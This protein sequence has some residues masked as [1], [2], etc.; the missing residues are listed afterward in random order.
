MFFTGSLIMDEEMEM[1]AFDNL[2]LRKAMSKK[3][4]IDEGSKKRLN[5]D[6]KIGQKRMLKT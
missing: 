5:A 6:I 3:E 4:V 2:Q 1:R